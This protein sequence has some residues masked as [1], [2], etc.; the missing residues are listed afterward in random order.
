[1][2][3][4]LGPIELETDPY[5][6]AQDFAIYTIS[7][8]SCRRK[9]TCSLP[10]N[11]L[12]LLQ[13][14]EGGTA[15]SFCSPLYPCCSVDTVIRC[16]TCPCFPC[17][18]CNL[19]RSK[20]EKGHCSRQEGKPRWEVRKCPRSS[21]ITS[22]S[23]FILHR[24]QYENLQD[25]IPESS[26]CWRTGWGHLASWRSKQCREALASFSHAELCTSQTQAATWT[27]VSRS[28][29]NLHLNFLI[30]PHL[31]KRTHSPLSFRE[32]S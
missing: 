19:L 8:L 17:C 18:H 4:S 5:F 13:L 30:L 1:M 7:E 3:I 15:H 25:L 16:L 11:F 22:L 27:A 21:S 9:Q 31:I 2:P 24:G 6:G 32:L 12:V 28:C 14:V 10:L 23:A 26:I 29:H 20:G